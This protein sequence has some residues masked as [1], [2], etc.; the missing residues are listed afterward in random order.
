MILQ[1]RKSGQPGILRF[2]PSSAGH[3]LIRQSDVSRRPAAEGAGQVVHL[4]GDHLG[5]VV[6]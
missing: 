1:G 2:R 5:G 4:L 3:I 6:R